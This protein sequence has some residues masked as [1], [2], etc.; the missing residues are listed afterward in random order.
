MRGCG[1]SVVVGNIETFTDSVEDRKA[2]GRY[3][4]KKHNRSG[5]V[6]LFGIFFGNMPYFGCCMALK[7]EA[8]GYVLPFPSREVSHDIW[9]A[10]A[11]NI[12]NDISHI[13]HVVIYR[14]LHDSNVTTSNRSLAKKLKSRQNWFMII[15]AEIIRKRASF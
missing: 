1:K 12:R 15:K 10:I 8:L 14:R 4:R 6:N 5:F 9:I 11:A 2:F 13:E 3:F 7:K